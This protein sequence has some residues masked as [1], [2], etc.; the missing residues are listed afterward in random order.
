MSNRIVRSIQVVFFGLIYFLNFSTAQAVVGGEP[1]SSSPYAHALR[2]VLALKI[3]YSPC[4][5]TYLGKGQVLTAAHCLLLDGYPEEKAPICVQD[6]QGNSLGCFKENEYTVTFP[7]KEKDGPKAPVR[8]AMPGSGKV[9]RIPI[10]DMAIIVMNGFAPNI[11]PV[12]LA[13]DQTQS[14]PQ[15]VE[16]WIAGQGCNNYVT[17]EGREVMRLGKVQLNSSADSLL[18][19][20]SWTPNS[21]SSGACPGDSGGPLFILGTDGGTDGQMIQIGVTSYIQRKFDSN[22]LSSVMN[23]FGRVDSVSASTWLRARD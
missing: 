15:G 17:F 10:P 11:P 20:L 14:L 16:M 13:F 21:T 1:T 4:T 9:I 7:A 6:I 5:G 3:R 18:Y 8:G 12:T 19:S 23:A 22:G 2:S